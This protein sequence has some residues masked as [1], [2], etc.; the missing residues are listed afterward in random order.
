MKTSAAVAPRHPAA[1]AVFSVLN[2]Y[3]LKSL[4]MGSVTLVVLFCVLVV[5]SMR[6]SE[7]ITSQMVDSLINADYVVSELCLKSNAAMIESRRLE[8]DFL[9]NYGEFG[10]DESRSRYITRLFITI[11]EIKENMRRIRGLAADHETERRTTEIEGAIERYRRGIESLA[12]KVGARGQHDTG[13]HG[14]METAV[15]A[16]KRRLDELGSDRLLATSLAVVN[17]EKAYLDATRDSDVQA[18]AEALKA[19]DDAV[20]AA[21][22]TPA[23]RDELRANAGRILALFERYVRMTEDIRAIKKECLRSVQA[24]EPLLEN[25]YVASLARVAEKRRAIGRSTRLLSLP[26]LVV[27]GMVLVL[28]AFF[29]LVVALTVTRSVVESKAFA[30]RIASGDLSG[31]LTPSGRNEF[32]MLATALNAMAES[33]HEADVAG[34]NSTDALRESE[35]KYRSFVETSTDW[36]WAMDLEGRHTFSNE[37]VRDILGIGPAELAQASLPELIHAE[38]IPRAREVLDTARSSGG[39]WQGVVLRWRHTDG[40][41]RWLES[42]ATAVTDAR[43]RLV[44][45]RG[46]DRDITERRRLEDELVKAQ[47]LEAIGTLAGGIAHDFN[48]L[49]QGLFGYIS[50]ARLNLAKSDVAEEML[51]QAEKALSLSVNLTTQLLT[52]A[53]GGLPVKQR[54]GLSAVL[55]N[56]V[57]FALS[58]SRSAY[59]IAVEEGLW[60]VEADEG[61]LG[62][63]I[64]NLVLN[65]SEAMPQGGTVEIVAR[66]EF[67]ERGDN[68]LVPSGGAFVRIDVKDTGAGIP[69]QHLA[70]IF[71][72]YFTTKQKGSG[73]GLATSYSIVRNHGGFIDVSSR[74][75]EGSVFSVYLPASRGGEIPQPVPAVPGS[76][77]RGRALVMD[78][79][80]LVRDVAAG[81]LAAL[82]LAVTTAANGEE[83]IVLFGK[84]RDEG[85][86]FD[87]VFLDLTVKS[88]MGGEETVRRLLEVDPGVK[89]VVSSGYSD[90]AVLA[91]HRSHG[92]SAALNKPYRIEDLRDCL[93]LLQQPPGPATRP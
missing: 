24:A 72:P 18:F 62:Q 80:R 25:L 35:E 2:R 30:E 12:A 55:E 17:A 68:A 63:V 33:L 47:K 43:G 59:R 91:D 77:G 60:V 92:F 93:L 48:N 45:F 54:I 51:E 79:D 90:A 50:L 42:N 61:Q 19:F 65:A 3:P 58:G 82:G 75:G 39:G 83:A 10:F 71:D 46:T 16:L 20:A 76:V 57:K 36:I 26:V 73:L 34:K 56:P 7:R 38:D 14:Y 11:S 1:R 87:I 32:F 81:M 49:L 22:L 9:L 28:T 70:R 89:A 67:I 66:N 5:V 53:K 27:G 88:G 4:L 23:L 29:S 74:L 6:I 52:F 8:K 78:D 64:Q 85:R 40:T 84:A 86:P 37:K 41:Y 44:G 13:V 31:R 15:Q 69:G 21:R